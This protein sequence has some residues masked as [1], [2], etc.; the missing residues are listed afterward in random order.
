MAN[1]TETADVVEVSEETPVAKDTPTPNPS[2]NGAARM[3]PESDLLAVKSDRDKARNEIEGLKSANQS[4]QDST[5]KLETR[6]TEYQQQVQRFNEVDNENKSLRDELAAS[7]KSRG[8]LETVLLDSKRITLKA[9]GLEEAFFEGK[10]LHELAMIEEALS[11]ASPN[12]VS[13]SSGLDSTGG[14]GSARPTSLLDA[15]L[16][17]VDKLVKQRKE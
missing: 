1:A 16:A 3:V 4:Y 8:E 13:S 7:K 2:L 15:D 10:S 9:H 11:K 12:N 14:T 6:L 17:L 5:Q